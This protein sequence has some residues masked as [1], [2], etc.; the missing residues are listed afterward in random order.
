MG[1]LMDGDGAV[2]SGLSTLGKGR[3]SPRSND[4]SSSDSGRDLREWRK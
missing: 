1:E 2:L 3:D 4:S